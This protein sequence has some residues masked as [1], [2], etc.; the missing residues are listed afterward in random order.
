M[1]F[2]PKQI[3]AAVVDEADL[4]AGFRNWESCSTTEYK[5]LWKLDTVRQLRGTNRPKVDVLFITLTERNPEDLAY[6]ISTG[7]Q[8]ARSVVIAANY[9]SA[10]LEVRAKAL[11]AAGVV[12]AGDG[13]VRIFDRCSALLGLVPKLSHTSR[14]GKRVVLTPQEEETLRLYRTGT[15]LMLIGTEVGKTSDWVE[16]ILIR[17]GLRGNRHLVGAR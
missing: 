3:T 11:G 15:P 17:E 16:Q 14:P 5:L 4:W 8:H 1:V 13:W 10:Q 2:S 6:L 7:K 9:A 12:R